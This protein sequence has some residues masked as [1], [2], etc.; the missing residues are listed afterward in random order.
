MLPCIQC[1]NMVARVRQIT[2]YCQIINSYHFNMVG[3]WIVPD[4][5]WYDVIISATMIPYWSQW[6]THMVDAGLLGT[7]SI[8]FVSGLHSNRFITDNFV[9]C[10]IGFRPECESVKT[11]QVHHLPVHI[12]SRGWFPYGHSG[13]IV[14]R[15]YS[16]NSLMFCR[17]G[18][19]N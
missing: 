2:H 3:P 12:P 4:S 18:R 8:I 6:N 14:S 15:N 1:S 19:N 10:R 11:I 16:E 5:D 13:S 7:D 17:L 9:S